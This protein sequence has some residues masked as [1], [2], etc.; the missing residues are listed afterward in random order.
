[1]PLDH[2][3][4]CPQ[5]AQERTVVSDDGLVGVVVAETNDLERPAR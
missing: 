4:A 3:H 1:M 2:A 5:D